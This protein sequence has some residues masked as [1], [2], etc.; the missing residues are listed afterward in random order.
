MSTCTHHWTV[1]SEC[2]SCLRAEL[3]TA[4]MT[5]AEW[6]VRREAERSAERKNFEVVEK[7]RQDTALRLEECARQHAEAV[8]ERDAAQE[9]LSDLKHVLLGEGA[10]E[11]SAN[12]RV[13]AAIRERNEALAEVKRTGE[14]LALA[15]CDSAQLRE[16]LEAMV[17]RFGF[18]CCPGDFSDGMVTH[19]EGC[20]V[21]KA[22]YALRE[23][24]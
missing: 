14:L 2:P 17:E 8:Q 15:Y 18:H 21:D 1:T 13:A 11:S 16:A 20:C 23:N 24:K 5:L 6:S 9:S 12:R 10:V 3:N 7:M 22:R 4:Q 19:S